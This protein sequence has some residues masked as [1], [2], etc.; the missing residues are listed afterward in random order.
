MGATVSAELPI[1][2][3]WRWAPIPKEDQSAHP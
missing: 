1:D 3:E 2:E